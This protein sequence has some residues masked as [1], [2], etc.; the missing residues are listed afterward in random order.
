MTVRHPQP[1]KP[2]H[3]KREALPPDNASGDFKT[4]GTPDVGATAQVE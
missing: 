1:S 2:T 4:V 3:F